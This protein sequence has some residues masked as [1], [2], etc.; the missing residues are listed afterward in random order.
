MMRNEK[1]NV[2]DPFGS[3]RAQLIAGTG[4]DDHLI[5]YGGGVEL[6]K[7]RRWWDGELGFRAANDVASRMAV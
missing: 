7:S 1:R 3:I 2:S 4:G 5:G 6:H